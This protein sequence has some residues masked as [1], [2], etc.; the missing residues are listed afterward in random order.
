MKGKGA[1]SYPKIPVSQKPMPPT[2]F[3]NPLLFLA[4]VSA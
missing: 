3:Q 4:E 1:Q 2:V